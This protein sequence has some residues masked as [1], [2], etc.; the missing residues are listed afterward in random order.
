[1]TLDFGSESSSHVKVCGLV[2]TCGALNTH[3]L[4]F[5]L[6]L[7]SKRPSLVCKFIL[8]ISTPTY[9]NPSN[10]VVVPSTI[11]PIS[12]LPTTASSLQS[13]STTMLPT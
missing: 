12:I 10:V 4:L 9:L 7:K 3:Y 5:H 13:S 11:S 1:M 2:N 6:R 8:L